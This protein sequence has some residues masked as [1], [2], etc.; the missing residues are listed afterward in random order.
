MLSSY[1][2]KF[3]KIDDMFNR[4]I[5]NINKINK[6]NKLKKININNIKINI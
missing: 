1:S 5:L 6:I 4:L 3:S 2:I